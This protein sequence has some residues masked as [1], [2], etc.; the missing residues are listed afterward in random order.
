MYKNKMPPGQQGGSSAS[1]RK[2][3]R[4]DFEEEE[5]ITRVNLCSKKKQLRDDAKNPW[6]YHQRY[7]AFL[8]RRMEGFRKIPKE[9]FR[10]N[11]AL[12]GARDRLVSTQYPKAVDEAIKQLEK[13]EKDTEDKKTL[14]DRLLKAKRGSDEKERS[15]E[16]GLSRQTEELDDLGQADLIERFRAALFQVNQMRWAILH[17]DEG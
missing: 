4:S 10:N 5:D 14:F 7:L 8:T 2:R 17:G 12:E 9:E 13:L 1:S 3:S 15:K 11:R 6:Q 16:E